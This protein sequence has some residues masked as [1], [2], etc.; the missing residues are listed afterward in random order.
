LTALWGLADPIVEAI[1]YHHH[2]DQSI[3]DD[4][5]PLTA[6]HVADA[7]TND[8]F[9]YQIVGDRPLDRDYLRR[10]RNVNMEEIVGNLEAIGAPA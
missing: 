1:A 6:V 9:T 3:G 7:L 10:I 5:T 8:H 2:P 4:F